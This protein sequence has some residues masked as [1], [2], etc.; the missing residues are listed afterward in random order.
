MQIYR[1]S[2]VVKALI[3]GLLCSLMAG[4][5]CRAS[6]EGSS[7]DA[8]RS[9]SY[10]EIPIILDVIGKKIRDNYARILTWSGE[11]DKKVTFVHT[12][13]LAEDLFKN[14]TDANG[15]PPEAILQKI[16]EKCVFA[17]DAD[18]NSVYFDTLRE[19][20]GKW[21]DYKTG[22]DLGNSRSHPDWSTLIARPDFLITVSPQ[23]LHAK[24]NRIIR[25][26]AEKKP[27]QFQ[28]SLGSNK[29]LVFGDPRGAFFVGTVSWDSLD[30]LIK[31]INAY[32]KIEFD[33]YAFKMEERTKDNNTIEY[34]MIAPGV[35]NPERS[36]PEHYATITRIFSSQ[37]GFNMIYFEFAAG[38]GTVLQT[39][40]WEYESV[41]GVYLPKRMVAKFYG[42]NGEVTSE[43]DHTYVKNVL[44]QK[45]PPDTF[46]YTNLNLKD[47]DIF[48][49]KILNKEYRYKGDTRTLEPMKKK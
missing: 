14:D 47:G 46:E 36:K 12:G 4:H 27:P 39:Y 15:P 43:Y 44:N 49:D 28:P 37:S 18:T 16:E 5:S 42:E 20:P 9:L 11:I 21:F 10:D 35:V 32:G 30:S 29:G 3:C 33:G 7:V 34:K 8:I 26:K 31:R 38:N 40:T 2:C 41:N 24:E 1:Q 48:I 45:I 23:T 17:F 13:S 22:A 19:K 6:A 25:R